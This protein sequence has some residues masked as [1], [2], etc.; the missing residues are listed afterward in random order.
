VIYGKFGGADLEIN[1]QEVKVLREVE[2]L[3][4][5]TK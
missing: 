1:G 5:I 4:K 3:A 2:I